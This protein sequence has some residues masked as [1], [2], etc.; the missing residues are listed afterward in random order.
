MSASR[1]KLALI[2]SGVAL[3]AFTVLAWTQTWF[4]I[5]LNNG[6][7]LDVRG[8]TA[9]GAVSALAL[10]A[11][12]LNGA[13][14]IAGPVFRVV[15]GV[16]EISVGGTIVL[17]GV[18]ALGDPIVASSVA[19]SQATGVSGASAVAAAVHSV[20][21]TPWPVVSTVTG[22]LL[23]LLGPTVA[24][25]ASRWPV[26]GRKYSAVRLES[27]DGST[28]DDWDALSRGDDPT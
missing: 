8:D 3:A 1:L 2:V 4:A 20:G 25:T 12:A 18:M 6:P 14:A 17:S 15:L 19:I 11:L 28:I 16:L 13:L 21:S 9:A 22:A 23:V 10:T 26:S 5:E 27:A 24:V 7:T